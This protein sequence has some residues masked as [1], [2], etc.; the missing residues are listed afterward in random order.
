MLQIARQ[1]VRS[2]AGKLLRLARRSLQVVVAV[3]VVVVPFA[4]AVTSVHNDVLLAAGCG[5][6]IG[7]GLSLRTYS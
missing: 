4:Y 7:V 1:R 6:A 5:L 3:A 2:A